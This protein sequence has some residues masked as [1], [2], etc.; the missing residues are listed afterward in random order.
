MT[1]AEILL[2]QVRDACAALGIQPSTFGRLAVNDGKLVPRL[3][4]GGRVTRATIERVHRFIE[5]KGAAPAGSLKGSIPGLEPEAPPEHAFRFF[6][7]RQKYQMFVGTSSEKQVIADLALEEIDRAALAPPAI[8]LFDGGAGDGTALARMLRG[9]HRRHPSA[10]VY[11][12]AQEVSMENVRLT[13]DKMHD[14]FQEHPA[15]LLAITNMR[16]REAP[17]LTPEGGQPIVWHE[18][19]LTGSSAGEFEAQIEALTPFLAANWQARISERS[20]N[21][22]YLQP[23]VL[24]LYRADQRFLIEPLLPKRDAARADFDL[25]LVSHAWRAQ[26][27]IAFKAGRILAPLARALGPGGRLLAVQGHGYNPGM[28][29][30][31]AVWPGEDP[32]Q[33]DRH[34]LLRATKRDLGADAGEY[35]FHALPSSRAIFRY[36][37]HALPTETDPGDAN[38]PISTLFAA[39]NAATYVAQIEDPRLAAAMR[40][41]AYLQATR[42]VLRRHRGLWF[43]DEMFVISRREA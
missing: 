14:R 36:D 11:A 32:F 12:V 25:V 1:A 34:E 20:G 30:V 24:L 27:S 21:P 33:H 10:P 35:R 41:E 38:I 19:A 37:M 42:A 13:L 31:R 29:I 26:A 15:T 17:W 40:E 28:E 23:A 8:R 2:A 39:W 7:N 6:D 18:V 4:Q 43:N 22:V 3:A 5:E 9:L 16:Y